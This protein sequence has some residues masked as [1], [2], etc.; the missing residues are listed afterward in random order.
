MELGVY[1]TISVDKEDCTGNLRYLITLNDTFQLASESY[2]LMEDCFE[3][4]LSLRE[5]QI[6]ILLEC[7]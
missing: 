3:N 6:N 7:K 1:Y 5:Y 4:M 2:E